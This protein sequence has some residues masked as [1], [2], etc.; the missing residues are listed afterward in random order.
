MRAAEHE[1]ASGVHVDVVVVVAVLLEDDR[2]DDLLDEVGRITESDDALLVL[3][4]DQHALEGDRLAVLVL[5]RDL[6]LAVRAQVRHR[7][8]L[9]T[10]ASRSASRCAVQI[11]NGSRSGVSLHA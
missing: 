1:R 11:G 6:G 7:P 2:T 9:R 8:D 10:S 4:A 5:E 3:G